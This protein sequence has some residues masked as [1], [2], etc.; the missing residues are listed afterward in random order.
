MAIDG[1]EAGALRAI[2]HCTWAADWDSTQIADGEHL[3]TVTASSRTGNA[4]D[5]ITVLVNQLGEWREKHILGTQ[6]GPNEN[7]RHWPSRRGREHPVS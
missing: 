3:L 6:L 5:R 1:H 7:G 4:T 2:D